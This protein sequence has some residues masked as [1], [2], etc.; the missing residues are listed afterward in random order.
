M[1][2]LVAEDKNGTI[3]GLPKQD[4]LS[5]GGSSIDTV[6]KRNGLMHDEHVG[7]GWDLDQILRLHKNGGRFH[8]VPLHHL[9]D[10]TLATYLE[11]ARHGRGVGPGVQTL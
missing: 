10:E 5:N 4:H 6:A 8:E 9:A 2:A 1:A 3:D 11:K 7:A